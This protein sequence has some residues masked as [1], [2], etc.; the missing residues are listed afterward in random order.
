M[1]VAASLHLQS[2]CEEDVLRSVIVQVREVL[3]VTVAG[4]QQQNYPQPDTITLYDL[5]IL[6][7]SNHL[8]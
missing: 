2:V 3:K 1:D 7:G 6:L 8:L 4:H 5:L